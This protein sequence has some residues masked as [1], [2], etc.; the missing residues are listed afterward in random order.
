MEMA[1]SLLAQTVAAVM[2]SDSVSL[3]PFTP[4]SEV[5][6]YAIL[7][8]DTSFANPKLL[9]ALPAAD[10][11]HSAGTEVQLLGHTSRAV[12]LPK[13]ET[14]SHTFNFDGLASSDTTIHTSSVRAKVIV[15][16]VPT[17]PVDQADMALMVDLDGVETNFFL[18]R[19]PFRSEAWKE[20]VL[21]NEM[22]CQLPIVNLSKGSHTITIKAMD[23]HIVVDWVGVAVQTN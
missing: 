14:L 5:A 23:S 4:S 18:L 19:E 16:L 20:H 3:Y 17:H 9:F 11:I 22:V 10:L 15:S 2:S 1:D 8:P 7:P 21:N 13:G 6:T 12:S